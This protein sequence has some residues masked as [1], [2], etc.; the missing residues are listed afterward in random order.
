MYFTREFAQLHGRQ[1][2]TFIAVGDMAIP[3]VFQRF[4]DSRSLATVSRLIGDAGK[5]PDMILI[6]KVCSVLISFP[7]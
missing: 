6:R 3:V 1:T 2:A 5:I 7:S 4:T